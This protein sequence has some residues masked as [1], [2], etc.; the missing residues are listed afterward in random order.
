[1][2]YSS[3][4]LIAI[5]IPTVSLG[6]RKAPKRLRITTVKKVSNIG[7]ERKNVHSLN[8][9]GRTALYTALRKGALKIDVS[10]ND[11]SKIN[12]AEVGL[13]FNKRRNTNVMSLVCYFAYK[14][15][16]ESL[17]LLKRN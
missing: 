3:S 8:E 14:I 4:E 15:T 13:K 11:E 9:F 1:M 10:T 12:C 16:L 7:T 2:P 17:T 5:V 6:S